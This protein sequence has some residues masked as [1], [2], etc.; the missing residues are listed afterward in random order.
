MTGTIMT[1]AIQ[2]RELNQKD[3]LAGGILMTWMD[4][5]AGITSQRF[6]GPHVTTVGI[7][8]V[9]FREPI[10]NGDVITIR[11]EVE[12]SGRTS[13]TVRVTVTIDGKDAPSVEGL[14]TYVAVDDEGRPRQ[15]KQD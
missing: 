7:N 13:V 11:G 6:A 1:R 5:I 12:K 10:N 3:V 8:D 15:I 4:E 9:V 14:F 2:P